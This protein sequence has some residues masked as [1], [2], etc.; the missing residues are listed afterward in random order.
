MDIDAEVD[1]DTDR[2]FGCFDNSEIASPVSWFH[3]AIV[4]CTSTILYLR[5]V[6]AITSV[7]IL[8]SNFGSLLLQQKHLMRIIT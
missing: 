4:S 3:K 1:A 2:Y 8:R 7:S 6:L 5:M